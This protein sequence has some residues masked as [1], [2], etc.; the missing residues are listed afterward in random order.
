MQDYIQ[1]TVTMSKTEAGNR[2]NYLSFQVCD[3]HVQPE[4]HKT[5]LLLNGLNSHKLDF[6]VAWAFKW[7]W[8]EQL[9][10]SW[11]NSKIRSDKNNR[12]KNELI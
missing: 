3:L 6:L 11:Y 1:K 4:T 10:A 7:Q 8:W 2:Q 9:H 12:Q 5:G